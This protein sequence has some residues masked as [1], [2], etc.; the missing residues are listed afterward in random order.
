MLKQIIILGP[1]KSKIKEAVHCTLPV[2]VNQEAVLQTMIDL[3]P[4]YERDIASCRV[5]IDHQFIDSQMRSITDK[6]EIALI[7]PVSGG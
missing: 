7:P 1:L 3:F 2:E 4:A 6:S 5:A